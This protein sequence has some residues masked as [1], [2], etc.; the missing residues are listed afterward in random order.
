MVFEVSVTSITDCCNCDLWKELRILTPRKNRTKLSRAVWMASL[1]LQ[2]VRIY[3][4][5]STAAFIL[6]CQNSSNIKVFR[7]VIK[8]WLYAWKLCRS[9]TGNIYVDLLESLIKWLFLYICA[10]DYRIS[11]LVVIWP[12]YRMSQ[13]WS[14]LTFIVL[15]SFRI[16][17]A[18]LQNNVAMHNTKPTSTR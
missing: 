6:M 18:T 7:G 14:T 11:E 4:Q 17:Q 5:I 2:T 10:E 1:K 8:G 13:I 3:L 9:P 15:W 16:W 12:V